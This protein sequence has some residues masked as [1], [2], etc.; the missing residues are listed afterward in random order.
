MNILCVIIHIGF[1]GEMELTECT[2]TMCYSYICHLMHNVPVVM[3]IRTYP[4][5]LL[6]KTM[7]HTSGNPVKEQALE[8]G[9]CEL[10]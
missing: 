10:V 8:F 5:Q 7:H 2:H 9:Y 6:D 1:P 4:I 3:Y